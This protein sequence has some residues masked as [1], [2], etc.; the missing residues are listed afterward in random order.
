MSKRHQLQD[1]KAQQVRMCHFTLLLPCK[2][3]QFLKVLNHGTGL[4][5]AMKLDLI[6]WHFDF[7]RHKEGRYSARVVQPDG[8][9][10]FAEHLSQQNMGADVASGAKELVTTTVVDMCKA[11]GIN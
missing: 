6:L 7:H 3:N 4:W 2:V 5:Q 10:M 8:L 9:C 11:F 1:C